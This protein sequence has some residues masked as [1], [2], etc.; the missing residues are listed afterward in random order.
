MVMRRAPRL[1][2]A[3]CFALL[4]VLSPSCGT[5]REKDVIKLENMPTFTSTSNEPVLM[6]YK[7][8]TGQVEKL[9]V[10]IDTDIQVEFGARKVPMKSQVK[11]EAKAAV[12][13]V[14][15]EGNMTAVVKITRMQM[16][17]EA[18]PAVAE[19]DSDK[20]AKDPI[21]KEERAK[22]NVDFPCKMS[23]VGKMLLTDLE[24]LRLAAR[25]AND[26]ALA[27][28]LEDSAKQ[29][30]DGIYVQLSE[31]PV[32][33]GDTYK[34]G[35]SITDKRKIHNSYKI[36]A[37]SGDKSEVLME[38][39]PTFELVPGAFG[40]SADVKIKNQKV[41]GWILYDTQKG[42]ISKADIRM[43]LDLEI[44]ALGQVGTGAITM[45]TTVMSTLE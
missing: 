20:P 28:T 4:A 36:T 7:L 3:W 21:F 45:K 6:R 25:K 44:N 14:D 8:K 10:D 18:G 1:G 27:K 26:A 35:S 22:I 19:F 23:P 37:V 33:A 24:P 9:V 43:K 2:A 17:I 30:L 31:K 32:K 38:P 15:G 12:T 41:V 39:M 40:Q 11:L 29:M 34:A 13:A 42:H 5:A 16:K